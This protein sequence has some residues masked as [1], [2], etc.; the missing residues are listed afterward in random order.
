MEWNIVVSIK[1]HGLK[2]VRNF[3]SEYGKLQLTDYFNVM[4]MQVDDI[5]YFLDAMHVHFN[6]HHSVFDYVGRIVPVSHLFL[7]QS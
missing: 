7:F 4:V 1:N 5:D 2:A 3:L 6:L